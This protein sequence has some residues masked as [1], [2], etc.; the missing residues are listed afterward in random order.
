MGAESAQGLRAAAAS[1][2]RSQDDTGPRTKYTSGDG[3]SAVID[4]SATYGALRFDVEVEV[5]GLTLSSDALR[6]AE[7][8]LF[9]R[10]TCAI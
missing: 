5:D 3:R 7:G 10:A 9:A 6:D 2:I 8:V 1:G 4:A